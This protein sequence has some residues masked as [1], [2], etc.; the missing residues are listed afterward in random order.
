[1]A[2]KKILWQ[3]YLPYLLII[4]LTIVALTWYALWAHKNFYIQQMAAGL[5]IRATLLEKPLAAFLLSGN[6]AAV[7]SLCKEAGHRTATRYTV[8][9]PDGTVVGDTEEEPARMEKHHTRQEISEALKGKTGFATRYSNTRQVT[10]M[11]LAMPLYQDNHFLAVIR[12]S[13]PLTSIEESLSST[14]TRMALGGL[15][16][17]ILAAGLCLIVARR[18]TR[19]LEL[20]KAGADRFSLGYLERKLPVPDTVEIGRLAEAMNDMAAQL[21]QRIKTITRQRTEQEAI[22]LSMAEGV[23]AVDSD[24]RIININ[25]TAAGFFKVDPEAVVKRILHEVIRIP[26]LQQLVGRIFTEQHTIEAPLVLPDKFPRYL[27][28]TGSI[29][30]DVDGRAIGAVVVLNDITRLRELENIRRDFVANVSHELRTPVTSIQG[31]VETLQDGA[32]E[33][34]EDA[35]RFLDIIARHADRLNAIIEDL[36]S[37]SRIEQAPETAFFSEN[38][39]DTIKNALQVCEASARAKN[40]TLQIEN[41]R[42]IIFKFNPTLVEQALVNLLDNAIKYSK[43]DDVV[44]I[45]VE[46][47]TTELRLSV[48]DHGI[49]IPEEHQT[50]I[51]ERF[52][53]V[54][55]SRSRQLGGTGLGLAIVKHIAMAHGGRV[56][57]IS[58]PGEGSLFTLHFPLK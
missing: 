37:L 17:A 10:L 31:F 53:R 25:K 35:R 13:I 29:L 9:L 39:C 15:V 32:L 44:I 45:K 57:V 51:F 3:L 42:Q 47:D 49:G 24:E 30:H 6:M 1:M 40:I 43:E 54:D 22:L 23:L 14:R 52:Y 38:I 4:I 41:D 46:S 8:V 16:I 36:L 28:A 34:H 2:R 26:S 33:N 58:R 7:D 21:D 27:Q 12:T 50:R 55:K 5:K 19:P 18:I 56:S 11:Y 20:L 48:E